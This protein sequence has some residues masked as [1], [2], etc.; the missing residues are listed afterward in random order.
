MEGKMDSVSICN[1]ALMMVG[2]PAITSFQEE[3]NNAK[4][5]KTFFPVL[6]DRVLRDHTWSFATTFCNLQALNEKSHDPAYEY[7]CS[8]PGDVIRVIELV[9]NRPYR[10]VE[11]KLL[12]RELPATLVY[13]RRVEDPGLFDETFVEA[14][15]YL[16]AAEIGMSNTRDAQ[17]INMYR[18]EYEKRLALA[19][20]IDSQENRYSFQNNPRRSGW[21]RGRGEGD[22]NYRPVKWTEGTAGRQEGY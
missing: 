17:L 10:R 7:V 21:I 13:T 11:N 15:Q 3:N 4:L 18:R 14:L 22:G 6:R 16:L 5:C 8:L 12:V 20:S 2:I 19:R 1:L 9:E